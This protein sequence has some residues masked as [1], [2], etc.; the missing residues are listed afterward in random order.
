MQTKKQQL[1]FK[2]L[3]RNQKEFFTSSLESAIIHSVVDPVP[4]NRKTRRAM[5]KLVKKLAR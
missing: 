1:I 5:P 4:M 3:D 2:G